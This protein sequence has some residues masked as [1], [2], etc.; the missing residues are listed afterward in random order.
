MYDFEE[1]G[2]EEKGNKENFRIVRCCGNCVFYWYFA[3][4]QRKGNCTIDDPR[5]RNPVK[6]GLIMTDKNNRDRWPKA[7][8]TCV[9]DSHQFTSRVTSIARVKDYCGADF[10]EGI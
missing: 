8:V 10:E 1:L 5:A 3:G 2:Q 7:H 4:N 6:N 9:C